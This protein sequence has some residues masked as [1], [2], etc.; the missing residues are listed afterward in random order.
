MSTQRLSTMEHSL[1][2]RIKIQSRL[3]KDRRTH[4]IA[5]APQLPAVQDCSS[6]SPDAYS[7][8]SFT[9]ASFVWG[10]PRPNLAAHN[11]S[12]ALSHTL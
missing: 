2:L 7:P 10:P 8:T 12:K 5:D 9:I 3:G 11:S 4:A 1:L 6:Q